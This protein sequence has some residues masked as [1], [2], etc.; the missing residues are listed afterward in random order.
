MAWTTRF[1]GRAAIAPVPPVPLLRLVMLPHVPR[2]RR[3]L[4]ERPRAV[5]LMHA[6]RTGAAEGASALR[7]RLVGAHAPTVARARLARKEG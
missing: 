6:V 1:S 2:R 4:S 3:P 7:S 5:M